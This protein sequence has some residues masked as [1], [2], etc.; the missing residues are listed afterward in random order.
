MSTA[1]PYRLFIALFTIVLGLISSIITAIVAAIILV[2]VI[3]VLNMDRQSEIRL[4]ILACYA[5]GLGAGLTRLGEPLWT[6]VVAKLE[7]EIFYLLKLV[8][9][10]IVPGDIIF[11]ILFAIMMK[12]LL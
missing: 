8:A 10:Y 4:V 2:S 6:I 11:G 3:S 12:P 5:I 1:I 7:E 9:I